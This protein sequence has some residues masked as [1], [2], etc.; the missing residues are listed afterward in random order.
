MFVE[1]TFAKKPTDFPRAR[2]FLTGN[3]FSGDQGESFSEA[4][5]GYGVATTILMDGRFFVPFF[6]IRLMGM[7][8]EQMFIDGNKMVK[9]KF[10]NYSASSS[11]GIQWY[12]I[13]R[14]NGGTNAYLACGGIVGYNFVS[15]A[16]GAAL[17]TIPPSDQSFSAGYQGGLGIESIYGDIRTGIWSLNLEVLFNKE[18][19]VLFKRNFDLSSF[20]FKIGFGW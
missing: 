20:V 18:S 4:Y 1:N 5:S 14:K 2:V 17:S 11:L 15:L 19:A 16:N 12:P 3:Y 9:S 7:Q 10:T 6:G 8:S 13:E